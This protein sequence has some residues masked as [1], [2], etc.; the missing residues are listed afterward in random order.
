MGIGISRMAGHAGLAAPQLQ[1]EPAGPQAGPAGPQEPPQAPTKRLHQR[2]PDGSR[3]PSFSE[4]EQRQVPR[5]EAGPNGT[6]PRQR[7]TWAL[8]NHGMLNR[9]GAPIADPHCDSHMHPTD[10]VQHGLMP[11]Q[12][13]EMMDELGV[14][15]TTLMPIPTSL[16]VVKVPKGPEGDNVEA[17][18]ITTSTRPS[19]SGPNPCKDHNH[20]CSAQSYYIPRALEDRLTSE[21][22][23]RLTVED[24][25]KNPKLVQEIV[26]HSILY[27]DTAVNAHLHQHIQQSLKRGH[28]SQADRS[29]FDPMLT[30]FNLSDIRSGEKLLAELSNHP[31]TFTGIG[32][33]TV[34]KELVQDMYADQKGQ[35]STLKSEGLE[36]LKNLLEM[37]GVLG[38]PVVL[39][40]DIDDLKQQLS[41]PPDFDGPPAHFDGLMKLF[42]DER[43]K[44]SKIVWAH[45]GGLGRFVMEKSQHLDL[46]TKVMDECPNVKLDISW[47]AVAEQ[48][49]KS[50]TRFAN[51]AN[52]WVNF[53]E[54]HSKRICF[55]SDTLAPQKAEGWGQTKRMYQDLLSRLSPDAKNDVLNLTYE[56]TFVNARANLRQ[57]EETVLT[58]DAFKDRLMSSTLAENPVSAQEMRDLIA[59]A[60]A[61]AE[62]ESQ[63]A[64]Q[65][66]IA[67]ERARFLGM[68]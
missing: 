68:F 15:N 46:L 57:L 8:T 44:D 16:Q 6:P 63:A 33:I 9:A 20:H 56:Q 4:Y 24:M 35:S 45:G 48:I 14:R 58:T 31:G 7:N 65:P 23:G 41:S 3:R 66:A 61:K 2:F 34:H 55:G 53:I 28:I 27:V 67:P 17:T 60:K 38:M 21:K 39:H 37:A 18:I 12:V 64:R 22:G 30:G 52:N 42:K 62:A 40:C 10:Y 59:T 51:R 47:S 49:N 5:E 29:R 50:G 1:D 26:D 19:G 43:L 36:G 25:R 11:K 32:E 13:I 54:T